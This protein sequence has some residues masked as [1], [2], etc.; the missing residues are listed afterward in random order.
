MSRRTLKAAS[1][2]REVVSTSILTQLRDPRVQNVT[3]TLVEVSPD[4]RLAKVHVS[5]MGD[6]AKQRLA[7]RGL[8]NAAGFLQQQIDRRI[9]TRYIPKLHF[10]L[11]QGVKNSFE[12]ARIL[13]EL[14]ANG[15]LDSPPD[16][17]PPFDSNSDTDLLADSDFDLDSESDVDS[18]SDSDSDLDSPS[19]LES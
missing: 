4:M 19:S 10:V 3:V 12:V 7:L 13:D 16:A 18:D 5:V 14:R 1:A 9:D 2:I 6:A 17:L 15:E 11:D 8:Q